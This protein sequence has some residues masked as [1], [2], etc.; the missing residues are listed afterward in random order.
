M[1]RPCHHL[2]RISALF[3]TALLAG[4]GLFAVPQSAT[5]DADG[6]LYGGYSLDCSGEVPVLSFSGEI[7]GDNQGHTTG[8][9]NIYFTLQGPSGTQDFGPKQVSLPSTYTDSWNLTD[10]TAKYT[11]GLRRGDGP[12]GDD[13]QSVS[14]PDDCVNG[15]TSSMIQSG[16]SFG[17]AYCTDDGGAA[18]DV[19]VSTTPPVRNV[20]TYVTVNNDVY[21]LP[22]EGLTG[23]D[24]TYTKS[25]PIPKDGTTNITAGIKIASGEAVYGGDRDYT[26]PAACAVNPTPSPT[27][28][29]T[30]TPTPSPSA[31]ATL[32]NTG[33]STPTASLSTRTVSPD[34]RVTVT[35]SGLAA[36]E[37]VEIWLHSTPV[38]LWSG[39]ANADGTLTQTVTIPTGIEIGKHQIEV[40]GTNTGSLW[41]DLTVTATLAATGFDP[42]A[43]GVGGGAGLLLLAGGIATLLLARRRW[44]LRS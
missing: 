2:R 7:T 34:G 29:Q 28:T 38:K 17:D 25:V 18:A 15:S 31:T 6:P 19:V 23:P 32:P 1:T 4:V 22:V 37:P 41:L 16:A 33:P 13:L 20:K 39:V 21:P 11:F 35:A 24:G 12:R 30:N 27:P 5:A 40:R 3:A 14:F 43:A 9:T 44:V 10:G 26:F 42:V 36:N 8:T